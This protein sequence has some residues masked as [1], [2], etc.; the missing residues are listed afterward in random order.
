MC[1]TRMP[2]LFVGHGSPMNAIKDNAFTRGW[3]ELAARMPKPKAILCVSAHWGTRGVFVRS[4]AQ[5]QTIHDFYGFPQ[6][7]FDVR[8]AAPGNPALA[9]CI[10]GM[11]KSVKVNLTPEWGLDHGAWSVLRIMYP[12]ADVPTL[13]LSIDTAQPGAFHHALG[14]ELAALRED[15]VLILGSGNIVH[16]LRTLDFRDPRPTDW[17]VRFDETVRARIAAGRIDDLLQWRTLDREAALAVPTPEHYLPLLYVL[18]ARRDGD[19]ASFHNVGYFST[20]SMTS[21]RLG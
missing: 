1:E 4:A 14:R 19:T 10:A 18:G 16:N 21:V 20:T 12:Q 6:A 15:G 7:L 17:T 13:Q 3:Q 9:R 5:P 11:V 8:Y 2:A